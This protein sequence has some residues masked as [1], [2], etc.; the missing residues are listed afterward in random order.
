MLKLKIELEKSKEDV[1]REDE[2]SVSVELHEF[3]NDNWNVVKSLSVPEGDSTV[4]Q[5]PRNG[6]VVIVGP[7]HGEA[8]E[9]NYEQ[10]ANTSKDMG[11]SEVIQPPR[12]PVSSQVPNLKDSTEVSP[13]IQPGSLL[14][15]TQAN[16]A[17]KPITGLANQQTGGSPPPSNSPTSQGTGSTDTV[18]KDVGSEAKTPQGDAASK[19]VSEKK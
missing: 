1:K 12:S 17:D 15:G 10:K 11:R 6:R 7:E 4:V 13:A 16:P 14:P 19:N 5:V 18:K 2:T 9:Y 8:V 3:R